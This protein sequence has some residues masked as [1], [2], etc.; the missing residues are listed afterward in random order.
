M[1]DCKKQIL[2]TLKNNNC[3]SL[4]F[5]NVVLLSNAQISLEKSNILLNIEENVKA[6]IVQIISNFYPNLE[7]DD[8]DN[9]LL[10]KGNIFEFLNGINYDKNLSLDFCLTS[11]S[12]P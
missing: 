10:I 6:K 7:I 5:L 12:I 3:C 9:F 2:S 1:L 8:W 4:A 11:S